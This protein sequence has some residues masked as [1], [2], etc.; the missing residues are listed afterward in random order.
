[1]AEVLGPTLEGY[2]NTNPEVKSAR[3]QLAKAKKVL[4][5]TLY[6]ELG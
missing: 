4:T 2:L 3:E 6:K 1:M 5:R